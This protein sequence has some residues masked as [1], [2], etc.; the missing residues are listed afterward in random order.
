MKWCTPVLVALI[1]GCASTTDV[2]QQRPSAQGFSRKPIAD[3]S[4]CIGLAV[5]DEP[6]VE[7]RTARRP[8]G[9]TFTQIRRVAGIG[10]VAALIDIQD[11]P[12]RRQ[13][14]VRRPNHSP[15]MTEDLAPPLAAC[16]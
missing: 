7:L 14:T 15:S 9:V 4:S 13:V 8:D 6:G 5:A 10:T 3:L 1:S 11:G 12:E 16:L 2:Q